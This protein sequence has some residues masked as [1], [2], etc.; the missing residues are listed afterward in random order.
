MKILVISNKSPY[1]PREGGPI[2][3]NMVV[4]GLISEGHQVKVL[5]VNSFKYNIGP[6]DIPEAYRLKTGIELI[7]VDLRI[8]PLAAF[9]NLF[10]GR[11]YHVERFISSNF[12]KRLVEV[13]KAEPFDIV[14]M[15]TIFVAPYLKTVRANSDAKVV[16]RAH[17]I[18]YLIWH[19]VAEGIQNPVKRLYMRHLADTLKRY[20]LSMLPRFD[21]IAAITE[22][23][24]EYF[25]GQ[26]AVGSGQWAVGSGQ[27]AAIP[28]GIDLDNFPPPVPSEEPVSLF[29]I[30]AMNWIPNA[31]GVR[32]FLHHV[33]PEVHKEFPS[34]KYYL[35]GREMPDWMLRM[36]FPNVEVLGE[37]DDAREFIDTHG[38]MIVPLLSGSG[39]RIKIIE[40]M[41][42]GKAIISTMIGAE[43]IDCTNGKNILVANAP[44]EFIDM[45]SLCLGDMERCA[46]L[47]QA[48]RRLVET[49]YDRRLIIQKLISFYKQLTG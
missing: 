20:E 30:G 44:C 2:A 5:A 31:E 41:A 4:E 48:A 16:L 12:R 36:S 45:I 32:W 13:L 7:D 47:G 21:G 33:W 28:F 34:L 9:L 49:T 19:R 46:K 18:E 26:L 25:S 38:I 1:P 42:A 10:T 40:G 8:K 39:I 6:D 23:D 43:G 11:S 27:L 17:N 37:V 29:S 3:M 35:A 15:E 22:K 24:A 14:Q